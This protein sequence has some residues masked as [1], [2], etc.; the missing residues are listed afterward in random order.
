MAALGTK[1]KGHGHGPGKGKSNRLK[2]KGKRVDEEEEIAALEERIA[3][4]A[5]A[6]GTNPL[7]TTIPKEGE[8]GGKK[9]EEAALKP[10]AGAKDFSGLPLSDR[11]LRGLKESKFVHMTAIQRAAI[12]HSLCGH[13]VL[14]AAKTGSGKTLAFL[15]P[16]RARG[17]N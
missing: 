15:I 5:P 6:P 3:A 13:D 9:G 16:V 1:S 12:P 17:P 10:Y 2:F 14:G 4:G 11:T 7:G 8:A